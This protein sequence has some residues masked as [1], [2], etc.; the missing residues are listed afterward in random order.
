MAMYYRETKHSQCKLLVYWLEPINGYE[1][2]TYYS[3]ETP[4]TIANKDIRFGLHRLLI[5]LCEPDRWSKI[6]RATL[7][8]RPTDTI[9]LIVEMGKVSYVAANLPEEIWNVII[10]SPLG[11]LIKNND[12]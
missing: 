1:A 9:I 4:S 12:T 10:R 6:A 8:Y 3:F 11:A 7:Y 2:M 5:L